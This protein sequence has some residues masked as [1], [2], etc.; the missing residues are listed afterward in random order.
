MTLLTKFFR[1]G[2]ILSNKATPLYMVSIMRFLHT[3]NY[4]INPAGRG[5]LA[6]ILIPRWISPY[7][8]LAFQF[9]QAGRMEKSPGMNAG[10]QRPF[11]REARFST[12]LLL[13]FPR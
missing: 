11:N 5:F 12:N 7:E 10:L 1:E 9:L 3:G 8:D 2:I 4:R 6:V 13:G